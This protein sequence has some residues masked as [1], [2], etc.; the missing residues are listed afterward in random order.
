MVKGLLSGRTLIRA[1]SKET[2]DKALGVLRDGLPDAIFERELALSNLLHD[3]LVGM[4]VEGRHSREE[5]VGNDTTG[6]NVTLFVVVLV[7]NLRGDVVRSSKLLVEITVGVVN[8]GGTEIDDLNLIKILVLLE[9]NVL[10][11]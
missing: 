7:E 10:R 3:I 5:N 11:L 6:P 8:K 1:V 4:T 2:S 9:K